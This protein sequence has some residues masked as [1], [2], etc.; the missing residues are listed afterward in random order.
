MYISSLSVNPVVRGWINYYGRYYKSA[1]DSLFKHLNRKL[2]KWVKRK[3][4]RFRYHE[5]RAF[6]W[7]GKIAHRDSNL[8]A[9]WTYGIKPSTGQ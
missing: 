5:L 2:A 9:H 6:H 4:K 8:F 1:L 3:Y 7:L